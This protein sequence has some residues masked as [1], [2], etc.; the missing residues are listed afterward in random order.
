[1][2]VAT[3]TAWVQC[4]IRYSARALFLFLKSP[5]RLLACLGQQVG[6]HARCRRHCT[7]Q[8][9]IFR[10]PGRRHGEPAGRSSLANKSVGRS[11]GTPTALR[12]A[13]CCFFAR[14]KKGQGR[15]G[16]HAATVT[17]PPCTTSTSSSSTGA[18]LA[19]AALLL[20]VLVLSPQEPWSMEL[21]F[22]FT[23]QTLCL[24]CFITGFFLFLST[25]NA[26]TATGLH[27]ATNRL[28][29]ACAP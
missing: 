23:S 8:G 4:K 15:G 13:N 12:P 29:G 25:Y 14:G 10:F 17:V 5:W 27:D 20:V 22:F 6:Y 2:E 19:V 28:A 7:V 21:A 9:K 3:S 24:V 1:M 26:A 11:R 18:R 16:L